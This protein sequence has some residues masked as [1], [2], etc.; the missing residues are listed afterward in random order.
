MLPNKH[1]AVLLS[2]LKSVLASHFLGAKCTIF[3]MTYESLPDLATLPHPIC[4]IPPPTPFFLLFIYIPGPSTSAL[5]LP[6]PR[7]LSLSFPSTPIHPSDFSLNDTLFRCPSLSTS[8]QV[9]QVL[10]LTHLG[11]LYMVSSVVLITVAMKYFYTITHLILISLTELW[12]S[13]GQRYICLTLFTIPGTES[14]CSKYL[15][16]EWTIFSGFTEGCVGG[17]RLMQQLKN[18]DGILEEL[19]EPE[20]CWAWHREIILFCSRINPNWSSDSEMLF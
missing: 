7:M 5:L 18:R 11:H 4:P 2:S 10:I 1:W 3:K 15:L 8:P 19:T 20:A 13:W 17:K 6:S 16:S 14:A 12:A 9:N